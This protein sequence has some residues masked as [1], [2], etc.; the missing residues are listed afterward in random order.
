MG[1]CPLS[2]HAPGLQLAL[3]GFGRGE[4]GGLEPLGVKRLPRE[5]FE[6]ES[7]GGSLCSA[8]H[9]SV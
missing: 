1:H 8:R 9:F 4:E 6:Q 7:L 5:T 2:H 3:G